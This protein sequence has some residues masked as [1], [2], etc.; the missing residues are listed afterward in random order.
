MESRDGRRLAGRGATREEAT[1]PEERGATWT[2]EARSAL[3]NLTEMSFKNYKELRGCKTPSL[4]E[5]RR[6]F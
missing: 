3:D 2:R 6:Y 4:V 1:L 5:P